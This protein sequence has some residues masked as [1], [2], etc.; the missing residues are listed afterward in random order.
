MSRWW[1][2][3]IA[4]AILA[5]GSAVSAQAA[6]C[7]TTIDNGLHGQRSLAAKDYA[8]AFGQFRCAADLYPLDAVLHVGLGEA[9]VMSG[10]YTD[11]WAA[12]NLLGFYY[13]DVL[14]ARVDELNTL[15]AGN[16]N[17]VDLLLLQATSYLRQG[18]TSSADPSI[19]TALALQPDNV[20]ANLLKAESLGASGD[21]AGFRAYATKARY[22]SD[23]PYTRAYLANDY[24]AYL[25]E[26]DTAIDLIRRA[27]A[28]VPDNAE[29]HA[30]YAYFLDSRLNN[31]K[32]G[33]AEY[34]R[35]LDLNSANI[36]VL[37]SAA[38]TLSGVGD[39]AAANTAMDRLAVLLPPGSRDL[40]VTRAYV[41]DAAKDP[42][43]AAEAI[44]AYAQISPDKITEAGA[45]ELDFTSTESMQYDH[46]IRY[47]L[48]LQAGD[49]VVVQANSFDGS[50][51]TLLAVVDSSGRGV[52]F[53]DD[54]DATENYNAQVTFSADEPETY[55]LWVTH[56]GAG[57]YGDVDTTATIESSAPIETEST[58]EPAATAT[59][60]LTMTA[61]AAI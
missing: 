49:T 58:E 57:S 20:Y 45:L 1:M 31:T 23:D 52:A 19:D 34:R 61:E 21:T 27:I 18:Y 28:E 42:Q 26:I 46:L 55:T 13:P 59:P 24:D 60:D 36:N 2:T 12:Y 5:V 30:L 11:S 37:I 33:A 51:D 48:D 4:A 47:T 41:D 53:S 9:A 32:A 50:V 16:P 38:A 56:A 35:A 39:R 43:G 14:Q 40:Y 7:D 22:L 8:T 6:T 44:D 29:F 3:L 10:R 54:Y 17:D 15:V 25:G